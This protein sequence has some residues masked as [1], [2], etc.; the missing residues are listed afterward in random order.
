M[1]NPANLTRICKPNAALTPPPVSPDSPPDVDD[2]ALIRRILDGQPL[3]PLTLPDY[4]RLIDLLRSHRDSLVDRHRFRE[5]EVADS[6]LNHVRQLYTEAI[7]D[8][9]QRHQQTVAQQRLLQAEDEFMRLKETARAQAIRF[10]ASLDEE[11]RNLEARQ[12]KE[13]NELAEIWQSPAKVR[14][15]NRT[16]TRLRNLRTQ[17]LRYL[18]SHDYETMR[19]IQKEADELE[20][21]ETAEMKRALL[22]D[23]AAA[24]QLLQAA[25]ND[26]IANLERIRMQRV[27]SFESER[28]KDLQLMERRLAKLRRAYELTCNRDALWNAQ[29]KNFSDDTPGAQS[30]RSSAPSKEL[31]AGGIIPS[32]FAFLRIDPVPRPSSVRRKVKGR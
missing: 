13:V 23:Y 16:S 28:A 8:D 5:S 19:R 9:F 12:E 30:V 15:Y 21:S 1:R 22:M 29:A 3:P 11:R 32:E 31:W 17:Q 4:I 14:H 7:K 24:V 27:A 10:S 20:E 18:K 26:Q 2:S 6:A 25:H